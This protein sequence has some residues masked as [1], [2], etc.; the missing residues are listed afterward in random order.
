MIIIFV[1]K[2]EEGWLIYGSIEDIYTGKDT[3]RTRE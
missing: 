3:C 2:N 1:T